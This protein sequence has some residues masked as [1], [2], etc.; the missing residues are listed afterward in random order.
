LQHL[1]LTMTTRCVTLCGP[2]EPPPGTDTAL[3]Q[4]RRDATNSRTTVY[5]YD[6]LNQL[7]TAKETDSAGTQTAA[8][9]YAYDKAGNHTSATMS[10]T[11]TDTYTY[12]AANQLISRDGSST[13]WTYDANG[14]ETSAVVFGDKDRTNTV[15]AKDQYTK[16]EVGPSSR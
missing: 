10:P 9:A 14:T 12:N 7:K 11:D 3:T 13:G 2:G 1:Q 6:S 15:N 4:T 8:W 5:G 16:F